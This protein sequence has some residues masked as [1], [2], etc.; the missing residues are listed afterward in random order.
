[1]GQ[2]E[3]VTLRRE[4]RYFGCQGEGSRK[5]RIAEKVKGGILY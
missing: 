5:N 2:G 4:N 1:M 3:E